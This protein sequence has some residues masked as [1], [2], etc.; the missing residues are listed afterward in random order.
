M[1]KNNYKN[2]IIKVLNSLGKI[3]IIQMIVYY[4][5]A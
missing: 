4:Q 3:K 2:N 1:F 5:I